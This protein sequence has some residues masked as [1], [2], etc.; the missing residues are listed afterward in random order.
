[1]N[2]RKLK[3]HSD[4]RHKKANHC[5]HK[6]DEKEKINCVIKE[7]GLFGRRKGRCDLRMTYRN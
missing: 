7:N 3:S 6:M 5:S 2:L 4:I 1:M